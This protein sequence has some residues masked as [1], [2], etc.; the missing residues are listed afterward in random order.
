MEP[1]ELRYPL[2]VFFCSFYVGY[3][4]ATVLHLWAVA[5]LT[6][7]A[8][9]TL[10]LFFR[11][12]LLILTV[13]L[14]LILVGFLTGTLHSVPHVSSDEEYEYTGIAISDG[15]SGYVIAGK[16]YL[17]HEGKWKKTN[18]HIGILVNRSAVA[19][20]PRKGDVIW[21][22]GKIEDNVSYPHMT[23]RATSFGAAVEKSLLSR[24]GNNMKA[25]I[26]RRFED[27]GLKNSSLLP[28]FLGEKS[29][30]DR[31][32]S[33]AFREVGISHLFAVSGFHIGLM[34]LLLGMIFKLFMLPLKLRLY[35]MIILLGIYALSTGPSI[36]SLRAFLVFS[37]HCMFALVDYPQHELNL[38]GLAGLVMIIADPGMLSSIAFQLSFGA[39]AAILISA[40]LH[41]E[42][43]KLSFITEPLMV[44]VAAQI[45]VLP[46][47]IVNFERLSLLTIP[48]T[49]LLVPVFV[50]PF[51]V[52]SLAIT[53]L[54]LINAETLS[55]ILGEG[56]RVL[57][58]VFEKT[59]Y[60]I[61]EIGPEI[62]F[63]PL[64][65]S[66]ISSLIVCSGLAFFF[67]M[68]GIVRRTSTGDHLS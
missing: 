67:G 54:G 59:V 33:S 53:I 35:L 18:T 32:L 34:Y 17:L 5:I 26:V 9:F 66:L 30:V 68:K 20:V 64:S 31:N 60:T 19:S 46:V 12:T 58:N 51:F 27:V 43:S 39:T 55:A 61:S 21:A 10:I 22:A 47:I 24:I 50:L 44:S 4:I 2:F 56:L 41:K 1:R 14:A 63:S 48:M 42:T 62:H 11:K 29:F 57:S 16:G 8:V 25:W 6:V 7:L 65:A 45:A 40:P 23:M 49:L 3:L 36:S 37:L 13:S 52:G 28:V 38:L 15:S